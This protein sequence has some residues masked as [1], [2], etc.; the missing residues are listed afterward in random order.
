MSR[1]TEI[2]YALLEAEDDF[3]FDPKSYA[4]APPR[5]LRAVNLSADIWGDDNLT[6]RAFSWITRV[7]LG[8]KFGT[9]SIASYQLDQVNAIDEI[10]AACKAKGANPRFVRY[11]NGRIESYTEGRWVCVAV[12]VQGR[13]L[14]R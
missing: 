7:G 13:V 8:P 5:N 1:A 11:N 6:R 10:V 12:T 2:V 3:E 14:P 9:T 4:L